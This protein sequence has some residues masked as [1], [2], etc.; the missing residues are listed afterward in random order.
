MKKLFETIR[1]EIRV[2]SARPDGVIALSATVIITASRS[3]LFVFSVIIGFAQTILKSPDAA[4]AALTVMNLMMWLTV[5]IYLAMFFTGIW[6]MCCNRLTDD[7]SA[8][9][10]TGY[11]IFT[12][13]VFLLLAAGSL[14]VMYGFIRL[15]SQGAMSVELENILGMLRLMKGE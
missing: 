8:G 9:W 15:V 10:R 5:V 3:I 14:W 1:K 12:G 4:A 6:C 13:A 11:A 2:Y 7:C